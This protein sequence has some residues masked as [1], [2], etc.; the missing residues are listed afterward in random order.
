M[1]TEDSRA[2][3]RGILTPLA[4]GIAL[5]VLSAGAAVA[6]TFFIADVRVGVLAAIVLSFG[7]VGV[8][9]GLLLARRGSWANRTWP[10]E[11]R[12]TTPSARR[13]R[14]ATL[15][16]GLFLLLV[17]LGSTAGLLVTRPDESD[18]VSRTWVLVGLLTIGGL[19]MI[20]VGARRVPEPVRASERP[21]G[22]AIDGDAEWMPMGPPRPGGLFSWWAPLAVSTEPFFLVLLLS[23]LFPLASLRLDPVTWVSIVA[24][25]ALL[26][27][28][29]VVVLRRRSGQPLLSRDGARVRVGKREVPTADL[30]SA[31]AMP[32]RWEPD[33][34]ERSLAIVLA[35]AAKTRAVVTLR[36]RGRMALTDE[37]TA[38]LAA[39]LEQSQIELP[40]DKDDP[41]GRFS[42]TLYP[43]YL[44]K[45]QAIEMV[46][47][48][49]GD[50]EPL[51][52]APPSA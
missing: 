24:G 45:R 38:A 17:A 1:G 42:R 29:L 21:V 13:T 9:A 12:S 6:S 8:A 10:P 14:R 3:G 22:S 52:V 16:Y 33:A 40:H 30:I 41:N 20:V 18:H 36:H 19:A 48:P 15:L 51:G 26:A 37:Q 2:Q 31:M 32:S 4:V 5:A 11:P 7:C 35:T 49:P 50:G 25:L 46:E 27:V 44:T 47:Y 34:T 23:T 28:I 39:A 43:N